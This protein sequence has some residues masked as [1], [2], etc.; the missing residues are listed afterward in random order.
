MCINRKYEM[1]KMRKML[2]YIEFK[3]PT[4]NQTF[5]QMY[6]RFKVSISFKALSALS[7]DFRK[8]IF[9]KFC[10]FA[11]RFDLVTAVQYARDGGLMWITTDSPLNLLLIPPTYICSILRKLRKKF[12]FHTNYNTVTYDI[13]KVHFFWSIFDISC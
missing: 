3:L 2:T 11:K 12:I 13:V 5:S 8:Y 9:L 1:I 6:E 7:S 10:H 4:Y